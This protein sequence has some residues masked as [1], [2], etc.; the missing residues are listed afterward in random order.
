ML[1]AC[2]GGDPFA[3][4]EAE[5]DFG[6][7]VTGAGQEAA[8]TLS[9]DDALALQG[10]TA[11]A[12][13]DE[14][15]MS[16]F[17]SAANVPSQLV[18]SVFEQQQLARATD[19]ALQTLEQAAAGQVVVLAAGFPDCVESSPGSV[20]F[21]DCQ[22]LSEGTATTMNG[23]VEVVAGRVVADIHIVATFSDDGGAPFTTRVD[24]GADIAVSDSRV[25]G[26]VDIS[27][28]VDILDTTATLTAV[29]I[30]D[31]ELA[32]Q[33]AV[34]GDLRVGVQQSASAPGSSQ[35][36]RAIARAVFG[37]ACGDVSVHA[38]AD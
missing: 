10:M 18:S 14:S 37:P 6:P 12:E 8:A 25:E 2:G 9:V 38:R 31:V 32:E 21:D 20:R 7:Q 23:A 17:G 3:N 5:T 1:A 19:R 4:L 26:R 36:F 35:T 24:L 30:Y 13:V 16:F 15:S 28:R 34:G 22:V 27:S 29:A 33:C 11:G